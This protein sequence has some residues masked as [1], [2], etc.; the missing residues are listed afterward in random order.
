MKVYRLEDPSTPVALITYMRTDSLR[1][2]DT[3]LTQAREFISKNFD[4]EYLPAKANYYAKAQKQKKKA[5]KMLTKQ[6]ALLMLI[7]LLKKRANYL[8]KDVANVI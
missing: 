2:S 3:A 1:L 8:P 6:F 7:S 5:R 4:K